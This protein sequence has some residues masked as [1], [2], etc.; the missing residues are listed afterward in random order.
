MGRCC[1]LCD[2]QSDTLNLADGDTTRDEAS[3]PNTRS[4]DHSSAKFLPFVAEEGLIDLVAA[5]DSEQDCED[6][7]SGLVG[8]VGV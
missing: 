7:G 5:E 3:Y 1:A 2:E 4:P 8:V 6:D